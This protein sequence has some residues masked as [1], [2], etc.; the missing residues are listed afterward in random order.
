MTADTN[1]GVTVEEVSALAPHVSIGNGPAAPVD[2]VFGKK[3]DRVITTDEVQGFI[4]EVAGRVALR[5][6]DLGRITDGARAGALAQAAHDATVNG[7]ASYLVAAAHPAGAINNDGG[8]AALLWSRY[9]SA[10][11][12]LGLTLDGWIAALPVTA[13][14]PTGKVSGFF[15]APLF[16]D[17]G[18]S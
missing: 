15:P 6:A 11:D 16:P 13:P 1:W 5:L 3:A 7:A 8:Y 4:A 17:G 2:L 9:E 18:R 10:V 14:A 12:L